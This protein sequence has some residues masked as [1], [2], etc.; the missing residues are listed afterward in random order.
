MAWKFLNDLIRKM[1]AEVHKS[2]IDEF[3]KRI[4]AIEQKQEVILRTID[5]NKN[6]LIKLDDRMYKANLDSSKAIG[7]IETLMKLRGKEEGG[8]NE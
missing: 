7:T 8:N 3:E 4:L 1:A 2:K 6:Q 5:D